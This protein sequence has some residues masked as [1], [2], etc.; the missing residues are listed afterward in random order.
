MGHRLKTVGLI[1]L[2][3]VVSSCGGG[4]TSASEET[5]TTTT[6]PALTQTEI[7]AALPGAT[8]LP[9]GWSATGAGGENVL[10]PEEGPGKGSCGGPNAASRA[11]THHAVGYAGTGSLK[12]G[13]EAS[14][15]YVGL[16]AF[17]SVEDAKGFIV[18]SSFTAVV[19][20]EGVEYDGTEPEPVYNDGPSAIWHYRESSS[21][22]SARVAGAD[23]AFS[24]LTEETRSINYAGRTFEYG[25]LDV[26]VYVRVG[27][28]V[29]DFGLKGQ[30]K[31]SGF[32]DSASAPLNRP[33][34]NDVM[35][36]ADAMLPAL[37]K[38]TGARPGQLQVS[39]PTTVV[40]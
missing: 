12:T 2:L 7:E 27:D 14:R 40:D 5:T 13:N 39:D 35:A 11:I 32:S 9:I 18:S 36:A 22:G 37:L 29:F 24:K 19:C 23:E 30:T 6:I 31:V 17:P 8:E 16:Y 38:R 4:G 26:E 3:A 34:V 28:L 10:K 20:P 21:I 1:G 33:S 25:S 15:G